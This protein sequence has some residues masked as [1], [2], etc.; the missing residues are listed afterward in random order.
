MG[1]HVI[2]Y[3]NIAEKSRI[4]RC[5]TVRMGSLVIAILLYYYNIIIILLHLNTQAEVLSF[6]LQI[7]RWP[8]FFARVHTQPNIWAESFIVVVLINY[9]EFG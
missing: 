3:V 9:L 6:R 4:L 2:I 8:R 5:K 1:Q 7:V